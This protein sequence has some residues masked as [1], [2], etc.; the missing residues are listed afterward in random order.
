[1]SVSNS[2][3]GYSVPFDKGDYYDIKDGLP[4]K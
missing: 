2:F 4:Q 3:L 1:M